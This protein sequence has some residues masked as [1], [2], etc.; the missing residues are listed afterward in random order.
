MDHFVAVGNFEL[1]AGSLANVS[2]TSSGKTI[3][4][5]ANILEYFDV[6]RNLPQVNASLALAPESLPS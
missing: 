4:A 2:A 3:E 6:R 1:A 5:S